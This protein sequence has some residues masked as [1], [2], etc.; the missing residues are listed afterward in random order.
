MKK[1]EIITYLRRAKSACMC[2][3][4]HHRKPD[5]HDAAHHCP[6]QAKVQQ[7]IDAAIQRR[8]K[9]AAGGQ[10]QKS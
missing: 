2:E 3:N 4:L 9:S 8:S 5:L 1:Q 7:A 6:V 10:A